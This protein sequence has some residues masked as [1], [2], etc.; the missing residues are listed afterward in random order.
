MSATKI[1]ELRR[2]L[3]YLGES[4]DSLEGNEITGGLVAAVVNMSK[5]ASADQPGVPLKL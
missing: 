3:S 4:G 1:L 5:Q 2:A